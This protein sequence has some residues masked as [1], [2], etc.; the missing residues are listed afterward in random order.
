MADIVNRELT[1]EEGSWGWEEVGAR[2]VCFRSPKGAPETV[3]CIHIWRSSC[4]SW[5]FVNFKERFLK[6]SG[7]FTL[8][9]AES[10]LHEKSNLVPILRIRI[11]RK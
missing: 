8:F 3:N 7:K 4:V 11:K 10:P 1:E 5:H 2:I 9:F 6:S